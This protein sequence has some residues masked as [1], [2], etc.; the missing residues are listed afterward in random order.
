[1][2]FGRRL[3]GFGF[4]ISYFPTQFMLCGLH[5]AHRLL[6]IY[7]F[8]THMDYHQFYGIIRD[9]LGVGGL[10]DFKKMRA[11]REFNLNR[12]TTEG[13]RPHTAQS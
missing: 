12:Y 4:C 1:M 3:S 5:G 11:A 6:V 9:V 7:K 10:I 8:A 2:G 13:F